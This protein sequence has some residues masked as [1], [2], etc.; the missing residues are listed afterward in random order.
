[1]WQTMCGYLIVVKI[2]AKKQNLLA[3]V[4]QMVR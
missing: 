1:M 2:V 4:I 3:N